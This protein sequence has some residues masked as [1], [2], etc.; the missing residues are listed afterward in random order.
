MQD[1]INSFEDLKVYQK[2]CKL[3]IEI[4]YLTLTSPDIEKF[5]LASQLRRS[6]N[7]APANLAEGW[8][9]KNLNIYLEGINRSQGEIRETKHHLSMAYHKKYIAENKFKYFTQEYDDCGKMLTGLRN[10]LEKHNT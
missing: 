7:S 2:L 9:N 6:T 4:H 8:N 10:S 1:K 5:E 3:H